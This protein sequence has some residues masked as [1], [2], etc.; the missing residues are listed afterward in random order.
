ML[1]TFS[2]LHSTI[3]LSRGI[4]LVT[5][6]SS[7]G[8]LFILSIAAPESTAWVQA[9]ETLFAPCCRQRL[10]RLGHSPCRVHH[11]VKKQ[12]VLI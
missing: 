11:I 4:V 8:E 9:A 6:N 1:K 3:L 2:F 5:I 12:S 7:I 10:C